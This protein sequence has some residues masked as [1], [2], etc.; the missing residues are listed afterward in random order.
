[1]FIDKIVFKNNSG[2][3]FEFSYEDAKDLYESL[4]LL[5]NKPVTT[6]YNHTLIRE[7]KKEDAISSP[8]KRE[9][10]NKS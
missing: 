3:E 5:F 6:P 8:I 9:V 1:M 10:D 7:H 2:K 4:S